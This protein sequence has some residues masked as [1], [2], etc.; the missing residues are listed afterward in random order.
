MS[1]S[2]ADL[3]RTEAELD[4][5]GSRGVDRAED[6]VLA[7]LASLVSAI[8]DRPLPTMVLELESASTPARKMCWALAV[9]AA[10]MITSSGVAAAVSDDPL[11]PLHYMTNHVLTVGP[12]AEGHLPGWDIDGSTPISTMPGARLPP[13][14]SWTGGS[15]TSTTADPGGGSGLKGADTSSLAGP[16]SPASPAN[17]PWP[18]SPAG[19]SGDVAGPGGSVGQ[20]PRG[21]GEP[22][23]AD[24]GLGTADPPIRS[25]RTG[26]SAGKGTTHRTGRTP[27][28][29]ER[30]CPTQPPGHEPAGSAPGRVGRTCAHPGM[31]DLQAPQTL[32]SPSLTH[33]QQQTP[34]LS[35]PGTASTQPEEPSSTTPTPGAAT[36]ATSIR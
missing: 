6:D 15:P 29:G 23:S 33:A 2:I 20:T 8:D 22:G 34:G 27:S 35:A 9:T 18:S 28:V 3:L 31:H 19:G 14:S 4:L 26:S 10:L 1:E 30:R 5:L 11:A 7:G 32:R 12:H 21:P 36:S 24:G 17:P 16:R 25:G 13:R